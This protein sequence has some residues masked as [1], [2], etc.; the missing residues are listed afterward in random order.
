M[1]NLRRLWTGTA[2]VMI[3]GLPVAVAVGAQPNDGFFYGVNLE[4]LNA[5]VIKTVE[6]EPAVA[7]VFSATQDTEDITA[8]FNR[9]YGQVQGSNVNVFAIAVVPSGETQET[10]ANGIRQRNLTMPVFV[11]ASDMLLGDTFRLLVLN[12]DQ[13][14][15]RYTTA[16]FAGVKAALKGIGI[17]VPD[18]AGAAVPTATPA[19]VAPGSVEEQI[20]AEATPA[21]AAREA[22]VLGGSGGSAIYRN[23]EYGF[24]VEFPP[25]WQYRVP[26]KNDGAIAEVPSGSRLDM[27]VWSVPA[28]S[29][30]NA[31]AY[32]DSTL[33]GLARKHKARVDVNQKFRVTARGKEG[34]DVSYVFTRPMDGG[35]PARGSLL[36]R[37][38]MQVF[39]D[40]DTIKAAAVE[41]PS[42]EFMAS[43]P[44]INSFLK[45]F[46][47]VPVMGSAPV[48]AD[49]S[50]L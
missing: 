30:S 42:G 15:A 6:S 41:G 28:G 49:P 25:N 24:E 44:V 39:V 21:P 50:F 26:G 38:R 32:I 22:R 34:L 46:K 1:F 31:Q 9:W 19:P 47:L 20:L 10:A 18:G 48:P 16:D 13:E 12:D 17:T 5:E 23:D 35:N 8:Q 7:L 3:A 11:A 27:R 36:Y 4:P 43:M 33:D 2:V 29:T 45:S 37:G 40:G 14:V